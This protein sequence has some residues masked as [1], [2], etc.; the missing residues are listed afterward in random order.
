MFCDGLKIQGPVFSRLWD[1]WMNATG[2][3]KGV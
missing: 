3:L 1:G 2:A